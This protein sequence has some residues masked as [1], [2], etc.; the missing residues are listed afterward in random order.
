MKCPDEPKKIKCPDCKGIGRICTK[1]DYENP[2][3][4][5]FSVCS[6]CEGEGEVLEC[7]CGCGEIKPT[8]PDHI[9]QTD[10]MVD[11]YDIFTE[12]EA[13][14]EPCPFDGKSCEV[15]SPREDCELCERHPENRR[16]QNEP[17]QKNT[18]L[19]KWKCEVC[20]VWE[21][22]ALTQLRGSIPPNYCVRHLT[23]NAKWNRRE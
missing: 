7:P 20:G 11:A 19:E 14:K 23:Y 17:E 4:S 18:M 15:L 13:P 3:H 16:Y 22:C 6:T 9:A 8:V 21:G 10:K 12:S 1:K 5:K 2:I